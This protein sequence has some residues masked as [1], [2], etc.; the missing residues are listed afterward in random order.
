MLCNGREVW[1]FPI[2]PRLEFSSPLAADSIRVLKGN[3][4]YVAIKLSAAVF[5]L[6]SRIPELHRPPLLVYLAN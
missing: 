5:K 4:L 6:Y 3:T 2:F 1:N